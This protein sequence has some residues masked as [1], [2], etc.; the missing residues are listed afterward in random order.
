MKVLFLDPGLLLAVLQLEG[1]MKSI[2][3][4]MREKKLT[5]AFRCSLENFGSCDYIDKQDDDAVRHVTILPLY[6]L[7]LL[8]KI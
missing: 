4:F 7:S 3:L 1:G 2:W 6:A 5:E 8:K